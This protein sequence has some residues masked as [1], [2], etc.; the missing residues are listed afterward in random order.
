MQVEIATDGPLSARFT[1][2]ERIEMRSDYICVSERSAE[3][4]SSLHFGDVTVTVETRG[5]LGIYFGG[6]ALAAQGN[7]KLRAVSGQVVCEGPTFRIRSGSI[8]IM[9]SYEEEEEEA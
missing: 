5:K 9:V 7:L 6:S 3:F 2:A 8:T 1:G 4:E